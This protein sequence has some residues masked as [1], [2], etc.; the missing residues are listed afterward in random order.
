MGVIDNHQDG[1]AGHGAMDEEFPGDILQLTRRA[2]DV[3][4]PQL[5]QK[6]R[7][8][9]RF[10]VAGFIDIR[11]MDVIAQIGNEA[12]EQRRF[13]RTLGAA[14]DDQAIGMLRCTDEVRHQQGILFSMK[15]LGLL[16]KPGKW[17]PR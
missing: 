1:I 5:V 17:W 3:A 9:L 8:E 11:D 12:T 16:G 6:R 14:N 2:G 4:K 13:S 15:K 7:V 10:A